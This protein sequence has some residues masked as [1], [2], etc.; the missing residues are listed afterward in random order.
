MNKKHAKDLLAISNECPKCKNG[1]MEATYDAWTDGTELYYIKC[2]ECG[3]EH[4]D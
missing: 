3:Y 1:K 2:S 4:E